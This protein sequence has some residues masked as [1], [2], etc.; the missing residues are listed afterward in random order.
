MSDWRMK[1]FTWIGLPV[2]AVVGLGFG[3]QDVVPAWDAKNGDGK[4]GT[5]TAK[6]EDCGRRSCSFYGDWVAA[7]GTK[8]RPD[9]ILYDEPDGM[10]KGDTIEALDTGARTGVFAKGG[11]EGTFY[12][13]LGLSL[14]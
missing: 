8:G 2:I 13:T 6:R 14:A 7:D 4:T 11:G 5:F 12:L 10:V 9:V 3:V 1:I